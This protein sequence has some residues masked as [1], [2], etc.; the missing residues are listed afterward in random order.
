M[1]LGEVVLSVA[2]VGKIA[3]HCDLKIDLRQFFFVFF[4]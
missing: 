2:A 4:F 1:R 3:W